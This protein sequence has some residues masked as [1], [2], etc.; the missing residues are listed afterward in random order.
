METQEYNRIV[1]RYI[2]DV[3][4]AALNCCRN[5]ADAED[6]VQNTFLKLYT[7][8]V[9]FTDEEHIRRWLIRVAVN[10]CK[11][12]LRSSWRRSV[13]YLD[14]LEQEPAAALQEENEL[15]YEMGRLPVKYSSILHLYYYEGYRCG[16]IA[17]ILHISE[18]NVQTRLSRARKMLKKNLE[19][20]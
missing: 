6:A 4:R 12:H 18:S 15:L 14:E 16:E 20:A 19:E 17:D 1:K 11:N 8:D 5:R 9:G 13:A 7:A 2:D 3:Y 10:E